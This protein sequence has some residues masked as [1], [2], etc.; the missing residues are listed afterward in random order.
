MDEQRERSL[1]KEPTGEDVTLVEMTTKDLDYHV[2]FVDETAA[3]GERLESSFESNPTGGQMLS[4]SITR[5]REI[6]RERKSQPMWQVSLV[7]YFK[8]LP[9][10]PQLSA[11]TTLTG[12]QPSA[13][14]QDCPP[15]KKLTE[16]S[17]D[18]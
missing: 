6:V 5:Y 16:S 15:A 1:G 17:G 11:P 7:S 2:N 13:L 8:K 14:R 12:Q 3:G 18:G 9:W 10:P 4:N